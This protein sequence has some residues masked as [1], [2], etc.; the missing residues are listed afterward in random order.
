M[1]AGMIKKNRLPK[2][3]QTQDLKNLGFFV[4]C[5]KWNG[6]INGDAADCKSVALWRVRF[7]PWAFHQRRI[8]SAGPGAVLKTD[9]SQKRLGFETSILRHEYGE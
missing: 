3:A 2:I 5:F 7:D 4:V 1:K 8:N 9:G 6:S